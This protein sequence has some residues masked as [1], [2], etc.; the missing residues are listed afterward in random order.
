MLL[1]KNGRAY[2]SLP[3]ACDILIKGDRIVEISA[4]IQ[5]TEEMT[6]IDANGYVVAPGLVDMHVHF[7]EPGFEHKEDIMSGAAAAAA[8][9][10]TTCCCM[11]NTSP[12][13]DN[14]G[15]IRFIAD[16]ASTAP[17]TIL[18]IAAATMGQ[19]GEELTNFIS[20][21]AAGAV[22]LSDDGN[23][24]Q[25]ARVARLAMQFAKEQ[26][27]LLISHCEDADM[28]QNFAVNEGSASKELMLPGRPAIAEEIIVARDIMLAAETG[29]R[30][31]IAHVSTAGSV[32]I[33][34][35]GKAAG[36]NVTAETCPQY[37]TL[38]EK[39]IL[40]QGSLARVNPPL[41]TPDDVE[42]IVLGLADGTIDA[43]ATDHAP[44]SAEE[45][46]LP[47]IDAPSGMIGLE[48]SLALSLTQ[49]YHTNRF[50]MDEIIALMSANPSRILGIEAV[51][52]AVGSIAD[53]V[54]FDPNEEWTVDPDKFLSKARNTPFGGKKLRGKVKC[55]ISRGKIVYQD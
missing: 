14:A 51:G 42:A 19:K 6:A 10:V 52:V 1:I 18:P 44:H 37:F 7:R 38:N 35:K 47:L 32:D 48:T 12:V 41:R 8:G 31:H 25:S 29:A 17:I 13:A 26:D 36:A 23:A 20:L 16:Q 5:E 15:V 40:S 27:L 4:N 33:I 28:V 24:I 43:I 21:R 49:L 22:A 30:L 53:I 34:R 39:E 46:A 9:G 55:T 54:I 11:G 3:D 2:D 50:S 45:K